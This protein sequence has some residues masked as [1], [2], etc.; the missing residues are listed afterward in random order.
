MAFRNS[1]DPLF[2]DK[3]FSLENETREDLVQDMCISVGALTLSSKRWKKL[4]DEL[5]GGPAGS[6]RL[7]GFKS[8]LFSEILSQKCGTMHSTGIIKPSDIHTVGSGEFGP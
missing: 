8:D 1:H 7:I 3:S 6:F 5:C 2:Q 4:A